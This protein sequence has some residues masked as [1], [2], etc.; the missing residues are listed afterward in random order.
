M[1][2]FS[3]KHIAGNGFGGL[4]Q[5]HGRDS[6]MQF[7]IFG[8]LI[9]GPLI[10]VQFATQI[11]LT[12]PSL[13][14]LAVPA[15]GEARENA[16]IF[17][18]QMRGMITSAYVNIGLYLLGALLLLTATVR[19]LHDR[20]RAGWWALIL[21]LGLFS[22]GLAHAERVAGAVKGMP[23]MLAEMEKQTAPDPRAMFDWAV[24]A[25]ASPGGPDWL[26]VAGGLLLLGLL[27]DL[28]RA[29]AAGRNR[30]GAAP[31]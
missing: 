22:T 29:G 20:G 1:A 11:A 21:P 10:L 15:P 6:R 7:W 27:I 18:A 8:V 26:A 17:E 14:D 31:G 24:K 9:F 2:E 16:K 3:I 13:D 25:N 19:R 28:A 4:F 12:F 5:T 30:F 23:A